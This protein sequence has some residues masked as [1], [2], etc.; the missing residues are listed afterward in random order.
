MTSKPGVGKLGRD[1]AEFRKTFRGI[2]QRFPNAKAPE[3]M[4]M[5]DEVLR[6]IEGK[7]AQFVSVL[8]Q[9]DADCVSR[10]VSSICAHR[11]VL[12]KELPGHFHRFLLQVQEALSGRGEEEKGLDPRLDRIGLDLE[13][14]PRDDRRELHA[15]V[16]LLETAAEVD[17]FLR[18]EGQAVL[19]DI[20]TGHTALLKALLQAVRKSCTA[21]EDVTVVLRW[22][23]LVCAAAGQASVASQCV[24]FCHWCTAHLPLGDASRTAMRRLLKHC[25][26]NMADRSAATTAAPVVDDKLR[27]KLLGSL[28]MCTAEGELAK[29]FTQVRTAILSGQVGDYVE[30]LTVALVRKVRSLAK[31][32]SPLTADTHAFLRRV[33]PGGTGAGEEVRAFMDSVPRPKPPEPPAVVGAKRRRVPA[34]EPE[35]ANKRQI[36]LQPQKASPA[37]GSLQCTPSVTPLPK[38]SGSKGSPRLPR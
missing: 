4:K 14:L 23:R 6:L 17:A 9:R 24:A 8:L 10:L 13:T 31:P 38:P 30:R 1:V 19:E 11:Q 12:G 16:T 21:E 26:A 22:L 36:P 20:A 27:K 25:E 3:K 29:L 7:P 5:T 34:E 2:W 28:Y 37:N 18:Q 33:F 32:Q 35:T 15:R